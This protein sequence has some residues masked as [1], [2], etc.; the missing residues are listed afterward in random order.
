MRINFTSLGCDKNLVDSEI[1]LGI[2]EK[3]GHTLTDEAETADV[4]VINTCGFILDAT[5]EGIETIL[6]L[7]SYKKEGKC[8]SLIVTGC[9]ATRYK[10]EI[11]KEMPEV[12]AVVGSNDYEAIND[13]INKTLE[14]KEKVSLVSDGE[15]A[16]NEELFL[17]RVLTNSTHF[18]Y[19]KIAEGCDNHCTYCTIPSIKGSFRSRTKENIVKEAEML[20]EKGVKELII[21]AQDTALYG[22]DI[23]GKNSLHE[24]LNDISNVDGIEWIRL[25][26]CYP[27]HI[28]DELIEEMKNNK[29]V[30]N[31][32]DMPIQH[33]NDKI[34]K[35]MGRRS[36][37]ENLLQVINKL[38]TAIPDIT[39]RTTLIV[40]FPN[41]T[42]EEFDS[43]YNFVEKVKFDRLGVFTY[44]Q[45][46]GTPASIM[47]NQVDEDV[48][49]ERRDKIMELQKF[50]SANKFNDLIGKVFT[51]IVDGKLEEEN[52]YVGRTYMDCIDVD[53]LIFFNCDYD[54]ITGSFIKIKATSSSD[55]DLIG[56]IYDEFAE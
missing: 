25:L 10:D 35:L 37:E 50:V 47:E 14:S 28:Y 6:E 20:A 46:E 54:I 1:M 9:M 53:G 33:S 8:K 5:E 27:E 2:M 51:V 30:V 13:V 23:Y 21:V 11:F 22:S 31:Y 44:S 38:R 15:K 41:E 45:E 34:L 3:G 16:F 32:I 36:S 48:K 12:D 17:N 19:L 24:L 55:Y 7:S 18:A 42:D 26:Y 29:K 40:G 4:I 39:I 56:E 52:V 43:L 49:F